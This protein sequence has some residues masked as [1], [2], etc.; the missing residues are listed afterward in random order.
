[1]VDNGHKEEKIALPTVLDISTVPLWHNT[2]ENHCDIRNSVVLDGSAVKKITSPGIQLVV[3]FYK[4]LLEN[5]KQLLVDNI[6]SDM[7]DALSDFGLLDLIKK[8][9][10]EL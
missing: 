3:S 9:G 8:W 10:K 1:M 6:S 2:F 4:T 5:N 7:S